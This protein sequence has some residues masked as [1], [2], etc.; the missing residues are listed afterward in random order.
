[1]TVVSD[2]GK[3]DTS[4]RAEAI[5]NFGYSPQLE[6]EASALGSAETSRVQEGHPVLDQKPRLGHAES[7]SLSL[8]DPV[9]VPWEV[10]ASVGIRGI[11]D[12]LV[13]DLFH[14]ETYL[15]D[16]P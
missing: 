5:V 4:Q 3:V 2:N 12:D 10:E 1:M 6:G 11:S 8:E 16:L 14:E 9:L 15:C 13:A 7:N